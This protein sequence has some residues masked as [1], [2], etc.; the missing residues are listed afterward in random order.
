MTDEEFRI[1]HNI[2]R[3]SLRENLVP[4]KT[5]YQQVKSIESSP[6]ITVMINE[7]Y[8]KYARFYCLPYS[9]PEPIWSV[10]LR[11]KYPTIS[12]N[13]LM[14]HAFAEDEVKEVVGFIQKRIDPFVTNAMP[15]DLLSQIDDDYDTGVIVHRLSGRIV[16]FRYSD[17]KSWNINRIASGTMAMISAG[18][19]MV[20]GTQINLGGLIDHLNR[21]SNH[22]EVWI[23]PVYQPS[24]DSYRN[25]DGFVDTSTDIVPISVEESGQLVEYFRVMLSHHAKVLVTT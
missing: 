8:F 13:E 2:L 25:G 11:T 12:Q 15:D 21:H 1:S 22:V 7:E 3:T 20:K 23:E 6:Q 17:I 10:Y 24:G 18:M 16:P 5:F 14:N 4:I 9:Y 19:E